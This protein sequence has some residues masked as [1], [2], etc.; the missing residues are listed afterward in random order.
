MSKK[1]DEAASALSLGADLEGHHYPSLNMNGF[2]LD[3]SKVVEFYEANWNFMTGT[4]LSSFLKSLSIPEGYFNR[5]TPGTQ[6]ACLAEASADLRTDLMLLAAES[7]RIEFVAQALYS[8]DEP[9]TM[10]PL[11]YLNLSSYVD[12]IFKIRQTDCRNGRIYIVAVPSTKVR[13]EF[14]PSVQLSIPIFYTGPFLISYGLY[15]QVCTNGLLD[16]ISQ[17]E[18]KLS[19]VPDRGSIG[20]SDML[21]SMLKA[22]KSRANG[23]MNL[24]DNLRN[25]P[26]DAGKLRS[27][28]DM[29]S[30]QAALK[31][32]PI[33]DLKKHASLIYSGSETPL[34]SPSGIAS[35]YDLV[36]AATYYVARGGEDTKKRQ[37]SERAMF[38]YIAGKFKYVPDLP[39]PAHVATHKKL[40]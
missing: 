27:L 24:L 36:D 34:H 16:A 2:R 11:E 28:L 33:K 1:K 21:Y 3:K 15:K 5:L 9:Y 39:E 8:Q 37:K 14:V 6:K 17:S 29:P 40:E 38:S 23:Y 31:G 25:E 32:F 18:V 4:G 20:L 19:F 30:F 26:L 12:D 7:T 10:D 35:W 13:D 22:A